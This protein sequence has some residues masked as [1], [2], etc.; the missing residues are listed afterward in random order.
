MQIIKVRGKAGNVGQIEHG[1]AAIPGWY[2][3]V[4][5]GHGTPHMSGLYRIK[6]SDEWFV[7]MEKRIQDTAA[8]YGC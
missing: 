3:V 4:I 1:P 6:P 2:S 7:R 8:R 5:D